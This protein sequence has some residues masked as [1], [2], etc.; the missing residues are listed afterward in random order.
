M[1]TKYQK[2]KDRTGKLSV[3]QK[4]KI[5]HLYLAAKNRVD[6]IPEEERTPFTGAIV[7]TQFNDL[8]VRALWRE[9]K[10]IDAIRK[11]FSLRE[12]SDVRR[13]SKEIYSN[14]Y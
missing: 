3:E 11:A 8:K 6:L 10:K 7:I 4:K 9:G 12:N 13:V 2:E 1:I 5:A 14:I